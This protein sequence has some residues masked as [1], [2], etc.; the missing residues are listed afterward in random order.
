MF[1]TLLTFYYAAL[2]TLAIAAPRAG[3]PQSCPRILEQDPALDNLVD[4]PGYETAD[5]G[6]LGGVVRAGTGSQP[7]ILV[8]GFGFSG[9]I[10]GELME[11]LSGDFRMVAVTLPGFGGTAAPPCPGEKTSFGEQTW[12]AG[13]LSAIE[14]LIQDEGLKDPIV[15]GH[16]IGGTQIALRLA[17]KHPGQVKGVIL[18]AGSARMSTKD[19][20]RAAYLSTP[21]RRVAA[22]DGYMAPMWFKTVTRETWDDNN[23]R[24]GDYAVDPVRGLRLWREAARPPLHV[25]VRYLC[26]F[27]A[28][29]VCSEIGDLAVPTLLLEPGLEGLPQEGNEAY[30]ASYCRGS[31]EGC[32][33]ERPGFKVERIPD[34][35]VCLWFDQPGKVKQAILDFAKE[36]D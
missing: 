22:I 17:K 28:Q 26:E 8:P 29:D 3:D 6:T 20:A 27:N 7:M 1:E 35:R 4:P 24:P 15:V 34:S 10:F 11:G 31:W 21:A 23:F 19:P 5:L 12:T 2:L 13:A 18:L 32:V 25:W 33:G 9:K 30:I 36:V 14:K 16:W